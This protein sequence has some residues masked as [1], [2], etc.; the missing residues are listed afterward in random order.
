MTTVANRRG[1]HVERLLRSSESSR[2]A[3][4]KGRKIRLS[5]R[6]PSISTQA[7]A[8]LV[9]AE[10]HKIRIFAA[11]SQRAASAAL[12]ECSFARYWTYVQRGLSLAVRSRTVTGTSEYRCGRD[13]I[14]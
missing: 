13:D 7:V 5:R 8:K 4:E 11:N 2:N 1:N 9:D 3:V 6:I 14:G 12:D 10:S